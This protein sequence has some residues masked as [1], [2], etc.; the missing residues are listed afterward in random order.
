[1]FQTETG[2]TACS[3]CPACKG[4]G[5]MP[6]GCSG[7]SAGYCKDC[8]PGKYINRAKQACEDC[9][10]GL[11]SATVNR[12]ECQL[13]DPGKMQAKAGSVFCETCKGVCYVCPPLVAYMG[14]VWS[15]R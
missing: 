4:T 15:L 6:E 2:A 1:M 8:I 12:R 13:C 14:G 7:T 5:V 3:V 10:R 11:Y 9:A